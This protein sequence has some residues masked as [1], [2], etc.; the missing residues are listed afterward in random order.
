MKPK[1]FID[2]EHGTTGLQIRQRLAGR[3]D[4]EVISIP[5]RSGASGHARSE[6]LNARRHRDP[7]PAR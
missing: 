7:V 6:L 5:R 1:I 3:T 2:G 4:I